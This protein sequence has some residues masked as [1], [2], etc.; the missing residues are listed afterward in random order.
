MALQ[1]TDAYFYFDEPTSDLKGQLYNRGI[2]RSNIT[3][4]CSPHLPHNA[5]VT[6]YTIIDA[7]R[8]NKFAEAE[9]IIDILLAFDCTKENLQQVMDFFHPPVML[10]FA[11]EQ[12]CLEY[13]YVVISQALYGAF[14]DFDESEVLEILQ[15]YIAD[16][17]N[18]IGIINC[19]DANK[20]D[21]LPC[22]TNHFVTNI[23]NSVETAHELLTATTNFQNIS[24]YVDKC[25]IALIVVPNSKNYQKV[26][27]TE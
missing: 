7:S 8:P 19:C 16:T 17:P 14:L 6:R 3:Y 12:S 1:P 11:D 5:K 10:A 18:K 23:V 24:K 22:S 26:F 4:E 9:E 27:W 15:A 20:L 13:L 25:T 21:H 2:P